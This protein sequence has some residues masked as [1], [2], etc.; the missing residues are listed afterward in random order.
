MSGSQ[1]SFEVNY[2]FGLQSLLKPVK[3]ICVRMCFWNWLEVFLNCLGPV[4]W[5]GAGQ[6]LRPRPKRDW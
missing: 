4:V 1:S 2:C 3:S 5:D 6:N